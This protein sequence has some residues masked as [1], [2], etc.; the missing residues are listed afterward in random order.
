MKRVH[1]NSSS[2]P[3]RKKARIINELVKLTPEVVENLINDKEVSVRSRRISR[4]DGV[5]KQEE[6]T[7]LELSISKRY[8]SLYTMLPYFHNLNLFFLVLM[9]ESKQ[10]SCFLND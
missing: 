1:R 4:P 2:S 10:K 5:L 3:S 7:K 9:R 6:G 8:E